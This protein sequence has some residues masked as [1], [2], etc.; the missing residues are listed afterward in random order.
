MNLLNRCVSDAPGTAM[1]LGLVRNP[2]SLRNRGDR[3]GFRQRASD[4]LGNLFVEAD[5]PE[6]LGA[7][8]KEF[9]RRDVGMLAIDGGD[10]TIHKVLTALPDAF[11]D[12]PPRIAILPSGNTN[13]V[14]S[15]VG[16]RK[17]GV[18]TLM[19]LVD[20]AAGVEPAKHVRRRASL[21]VHWRDNAHP[22]ARGMFLGAAAFTRGVEFAHGRRYVKS[23]THHSAVAGA[24]FASIAKA[25]T[26]RAE[27][28]AGDPMTIAPS[29]EGM[30]RTN[31]R[32]NNRFIF[33]AT[34]LHELG[35]GVWPFWGA[36]DAPIR[37]LDID[38]HPKRLL[39]ALYSV[40][41]GRA[42][43]WLRE[44]DDYQSGSADTIALELNH[45]FVLDG[46]TFEPGPSGKVELRSGRVLD[47]VAV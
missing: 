3:D 6:D 11:G 22:P 5:A 25:Y 26:G 33:L 32:T 13:L 28:F 42:P 16:C 4:A 2:H 1:T 37:Y 17:P 46:E 14:A 29:V 45:R 19:K 21:D 9:A 36:L 38:A 31:G 20:V 23:V 40:L 43:D 47:F 12:H 10:G 7:I 39:G 30:P 24:I 34:T 41:R 8:L 35:F 27:W 15:D 18:K 44:A